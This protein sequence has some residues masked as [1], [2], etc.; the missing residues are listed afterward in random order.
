M[1]L[2]SVIASS[3]SKKFGLKSNVVA[4]AIPELS[5]KEMKMASKQKRDR[6]CPKSIAVFFVFD[7]KTGE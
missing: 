5:N 7:N 6:I 3:E 2:V 1:A 4:W